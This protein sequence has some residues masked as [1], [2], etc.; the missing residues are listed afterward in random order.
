MIRTL[1]ILPTLVWAQMAVAAPP[2]V[3]VSTLDGR[4]LDGQI[5]SINGE[6]VVVRSAGGD[7]TIK[8]AELA[9]L[10]LKEPSP[11]RG[12]KP[13]AWVQLI[14]GARLPAAG[15]LSKDDKAT[16]TLPDGTQL[17]LS[18][19]QVLSVRYSKL[20]EPDAEPAKTEATGDILAVRKRDTV[21]FL[22]GVIGNVTKEAVHFTVDG[23]S[24]PVNPARVDSLVYARRA[25][26]DETPPV[27]VVEETTGARLPAKS[28]KLEGGK[29]KLVLLSGGSVDRPLDSV[30]RLDFSAGKLA[31][32]SD[33]K[34]ESV[35]W[36]PFFDLG[37]QSQALAR[38]LGPRFD[39]G[40][41][42][43]LMRLDGKAYKKGISLTSRT[44]LVYKLPARAKRFQALAGIDDNVGDLGSVQLIISGD[45]RQLFSGTVAGKDSPLALDLDLA[46][47]RRLSILVD[48]G[49]DMDVADHLDLC[50]ARIVK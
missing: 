27:C 44:E 31:Y 17:A 5:E 7:V 23:Q 28:I 15:F 38:F 29:V 39:R 35:Q 30:R 10:S 50:E 45:G 21:D 1:I 2:E 49:D 14:D 18:A 4:T 41:E 11:A 43:S 32:L 16:I 3:Q 46:G 6:A 25:S 9:S 26:E 47:V 33:L 12:E 48:Y 40:R 36:T 19:K 13:A 37:K 42:E 8:N 34:P 22:E 24:I 20:D